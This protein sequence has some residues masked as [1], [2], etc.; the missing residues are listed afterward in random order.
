MWLLCC[1][2]VFRMAGIVNLRVGTAGGTSDN[3]KAADPLCPNDDVMHFMNDTM[4]REVGLYVFAV[5]AGNCWIEFCICHTCHVLNTYVH[6]YIHTYIH[7]VFA[8]LF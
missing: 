5:L 6:T 7:V 2:I 8:F 1:G 3:C 4:W